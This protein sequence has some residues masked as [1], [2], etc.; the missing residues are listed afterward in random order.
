M[1]WYEDSEEEDGEEEKIQSV[2]MQGQQETI[3]TPK[4]RGGKEWVHLP[5]SSLDEGYD[6]LLER[7]LIIE[8]EAGEAAQE[9]SG[10]QSM[11]RWMTEGGRV[12]G[13]REKRE[14]ND[15]SM[16]VE[17]EVVEWSSA[18]NAERESGSGDGGAIKRKIS[19]MET[20]DQS[21]PGDLQMR[22]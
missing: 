7:G 4:T 17:W 13:W 20:S 1:S 15:G 16:T 9:P 22:D 19:D 3:E 6:G 2:H 5:L 18:E 12:R 10:K 8:S 14:S 11:T 21:G